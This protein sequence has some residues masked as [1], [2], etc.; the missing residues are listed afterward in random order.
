MKLLG[1]FIQSTE[2]KTD[3]LMVL[4]IFTTLSGLLMNL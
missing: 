1:I 2:A 4:F 3:V